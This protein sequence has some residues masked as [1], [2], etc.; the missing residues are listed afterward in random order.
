MIPEWD[1]AEAARNLS[2][3][4]YD[5]VEWRVA[6]LPTEEMRR[7]FPS[8][9]VRD[10]RWWL[11]N[12][13]TVDFDRV[14]ELA[15]EVRR[16]T[17]DAG[18]AV[19]SLGTYHTAD[20]LDEIEREMQAAQIM[21]CPRIR[22][23]V[24]HYDRTRNYNDLYSETI[25]HLREV[26]KLARAHGVEAN[27]ETHFGN[28]AASA[29]LAYR[30]VSQFDPQFIGVVY[31]PGNMVYEGYE[32]WRMGFELLGP[33]LHEVHAKNA[34]WVPVD[35]VPEG[36]RQMAGPQVDTHEDDGTV[37]WMPYF[38]PLRKGFANW[39][40]IMAD[41]KAVGYDGWIAFED[42]QGEESAWDRC[43]HNLAYLKSYE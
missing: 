20:Q 39:P 5:G 1:L 36:F 11:D 40:Q 24:P 34:T 16:I 32:C 10:A 14:I 33:Y 12:K 43:A 15:P 2:D 25:E 37:L 8:D 4:G 42:M 17:E 23:N 7:R 19:C 41:L 21:G 30:L 18:L 9:M 28:I 22:V 13:A 31:D 35:K 3:L 26:E 6:T 27:I 38:G 29:S